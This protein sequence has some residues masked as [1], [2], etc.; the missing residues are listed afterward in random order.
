M[1]SKPLP[2]AAVEPD[3]GAVRLG[4]VSPETT[5]VDTGAEAGA[6]ALALEAGAAADDELSPPPPPHA[7]S[8]NEPNKEITKGSLSFIFI[9]VFSVRI[10]NPAK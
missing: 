8:A 9:M 2:V 4:S 10:V 1:P 3:C 7:A 5:G 6:G